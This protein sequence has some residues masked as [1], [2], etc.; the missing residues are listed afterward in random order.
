MHGKGPSGREESLER[1][2]FLLY[3][4]R[5]GRLEG[6][7]LG[8]RAKYRPW[9]DQRRYFGSDSPRADNE[10]R[11]RRKRGYGQGEFRKRIG[12]RGEQD[13]VPPGW[14]HHNGGGMKG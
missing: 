4:A 12:S 1:S 14:S 8:E 2:G 13:P 3:S 10:L 5:R 9:G 6:L 11:I 7:G